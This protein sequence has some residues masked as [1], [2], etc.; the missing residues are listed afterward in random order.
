MKTRNKILL[1]SLEIGVALMALI[2]LVPFWFL[3]VNSFKPIQEILVD[4]TSLPVAATFDN[5]VNAFQI[6]NFPRVFLN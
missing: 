3:L 4:P 1:V 5:Y 2:T 6:L